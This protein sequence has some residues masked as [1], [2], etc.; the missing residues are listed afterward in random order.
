MIVIIVKRELDTAIRAVSKHRK[1]VTVL[2]FK[3][4]GRFISH[5]SSIDLITDMD[6]SITRFAST[7]RCLLLWRL[8]RSTCPSS[9]DEWWFMESQSTSRKT[10]ANVVPTNTALCQTVSNHVSCGTPDHLA[11]TAVTKVLSETL[12]MQVD[13]CFRVPT[14][15]KID[16]R[17]IKRPAICQKVYRNTELALFKLMAQ[18]C[19]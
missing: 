5:K 6:I 4:Y 19:P 12:Q 16:S 9:T 17:V 1:T 11:E 3:R 10:V 13:V 18:R 14:I 7:P 8:R 15:I 2:A